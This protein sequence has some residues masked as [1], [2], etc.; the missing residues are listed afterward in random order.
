MTSEDYVDVDGAAVP[1]DTPNDPETME[2]LREKNRMLQ[3]TLEKHDKQ[4]A[5]KV[6]TLRDELRT[7]SDALQRAEKKGGE[8][9]RRLGENA[10][11]E[12]AYLERAREINDAYHRLIVDQN[13]LNHVFLECARIRLAK[14]VEDLGDMVEFN[15]KCPV[16]GARTGRL[17]DFHAR[18]AQFLET[19]TP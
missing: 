11:E 17:T 18:L 5:A 19:V 2:S 4:H 16:P 1:V 12:N 6:V 10:K 3:E 7:V 9:M 13:N 8:A 15:L 14:L